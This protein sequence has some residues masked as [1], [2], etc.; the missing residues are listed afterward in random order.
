[1]THANAPRGKIGQL[2]TTN[3]FAILLEIIIVF[4]PLFFGLQTNNRLGSDHIT[5]AGDIVILQGSITYIGLIISLALL[6]VTSWLRGANWNYFGVERPKNW[7]RVLL[8]I[9][10]VSLAVVLVVRFVI[11][12]IINAV[13][14][15]D[16]LI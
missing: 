10:R 5:I 16:L 4:L 11:N 3:R 12:P 7:W 8:V 15:S 13:P 6:W 9:L 14:I 1:M 2:L